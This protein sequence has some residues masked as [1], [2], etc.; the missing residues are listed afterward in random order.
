MNKIFYL[1]NVLIVLSIFQFCSN[2][3]ESKNHP[4]EI[5]ELILSKSQ[6]ETDEYIPIT[7]I[8]IDADGDSLNYFWSTASG[9]IHI[10]YIT[11]N[12]TLWRTPNTSGEYS[13]YCTVSD[14]KSID[15]DSIIVSVGY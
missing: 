5:Q 6:I 12:P 3:T 2:P 11:A 15:S 9:Y 13:V 4:P 10:S 8:A 1:I 14:G 7:A